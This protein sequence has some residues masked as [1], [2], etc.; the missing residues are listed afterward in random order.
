MPQASRIRGHSYVLYPPANSPQLAMDSAGKVALSLG[1]AISHPAC[2][3]WTL[4]D[5]WRARLLDAD[6]RFAENQNDENRA[7]YVRVLTIFK[8]LVV[9]GILPRED[10]DE[11]A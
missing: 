4:H 8:D 9:Y 7:E 11:S 5:A 2:V 6:H 3:D 1:M 10:P